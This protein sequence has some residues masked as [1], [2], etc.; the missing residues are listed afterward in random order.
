[1]I[2]VAH[3]IYIVHQTFIVFFL[4]R[5]CLEMQYG[6]EESMLE[7]S[8]LGAECNQCNEILCRE[9]ENKRNVA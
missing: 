9:S 1:M 4:C 2:F 5:Y 3:Q 6:T 7:T 8:V